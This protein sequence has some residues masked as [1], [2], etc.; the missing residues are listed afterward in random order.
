[1]GRLRRRVATASPFRTAGK[2]RL[3]ARV[4][5]SPW[6]TSAT[7]HKTRHCG[8]AQNGHGNPAAHGDRFQFIGYG[9]AAQGATF[10]Q[11]DSTHWLITSADNTI[12]DVITLS[13]CASVHASDY[14]FV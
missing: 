11:I 3:L 13:N 6:P 10:L 12:H 14:V 2:R 7:L 9:T 4:E 5:A 8:V 1:L